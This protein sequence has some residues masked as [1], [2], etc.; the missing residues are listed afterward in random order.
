[1]GS[2]MCIRDRLTHVANSAYGIHASGLERV[3]DSKKNDG[4]AKRDPGLDQNPY[5]SKF[6]DKNVQHQDVR[7]YSEGWY[8]LRHV[9]G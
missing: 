5:V 4:R 9:S 6:T 2:E 3:E 7:C 8:K 1:M